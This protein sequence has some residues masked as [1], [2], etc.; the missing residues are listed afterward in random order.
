LSTD[1]LRD[2]KV[3]SQRGMGAETEPLCQLRRTL[4]TAARMLEPKKSLCFEQRQWV[5]TRAFYFT[6]KKMIA[7]V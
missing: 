2:Y 3:R 7:S 5:S 6:F 4:A 1:H